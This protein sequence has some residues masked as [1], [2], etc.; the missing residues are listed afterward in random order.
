MGV[1]AVIQ[2][3]KNTL[4]EQTHSLVATD[5]IAIGPIKKPWTHL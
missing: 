3:G 4:D 1:S 2:S 5:Q